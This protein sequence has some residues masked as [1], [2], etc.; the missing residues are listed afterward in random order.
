MI[1]EL[2]SDNP[3]ARRF[4][5]GFGSDESGAG[6]APETALQASSKDTAKESFAGQLGK[7]TSSVKDVKDAK[8]FPSSADDAK[9]VNG[10]RG[11]NKRKPNHAS[12]TR[13]SGPVEAEDATAKGALGG[14]FGGALDGVKPDPTTRTEPDDRL[15]VDSASPARIDEG[16]SQVDPETSRRIEASL[17]ERADAKTQAVG[18]FLARMQAEFGISPEK[19]IEAFARL[20]ERTLMKPPEQAMREFLGN[21]G[22]EPQ[23]TPRAEQLYTQMVDETGEAELGKKM[24]GREGGVNFEVLSPGEH[25]L[26]TLNE[27]LDQMNDVFFQQDMR[28]G[29]DVRDAQTSKASL[30]ADAMNAELARRVQAKGIR[31]QNVG[32]I[33]QNVVGSTEDRRNDSAAGA[34]TT[35]EAGGMS[36]LST[37]SFGG[38]AASAA[39]SGSFD[40]SDSGSDSNFDGFAS[41]MNQERKAQA[42]SA[43]SQTPAGTQFSVTR[44]TPTSSAHGS[45]ET[46]AFSGLVGESSEGAAS[47]KES[48]AETASTSALAASG[49]PNMPREPVSAMGPAGMMIE[50]PKPTRQDEQDNIR[51][52]IRQAQVVLKKGGGEMKLE[53]KPEGMGQVHLKVSVDD[54]QVNVRMLTENDQAKRLLENGLHEL[55]ASLAAEK[56]HVDTMKVDVGSEIKKHMDQSSQQDA[57]REQ[58]RQFAQEFMG[59]FREERE[60]F[61]QGFA[62]N[63]GWRPYNRNP[64]RAP[65]EPEAIAST[66]QGRRASG[67]VAGTRRLNLVA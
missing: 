37:L 65:V 42:S 51:E 31:G 1:S 43:A 6:A 57:S 35:M 26:R 19:I 16:A 50:G 21:L 59:Q 4:T 32:G 49:A 54:G 11:T 61:R 60:A 22:L 66:Q 20:D 24:A 63:S 46:A 9:D 56:L 7:K 2:R 30:S 47:L 15:G 10:A 41:A 58:A 64:K 34:G 12:T 18:R 5:R 38:S 40:L 27:S 52:L 28:Q 23:D 39:G 67:D 13:R 3:F 55:K 29:V 36:V 33:G 45:M 62:E 17:V 14:A 25:R 53:M 48:T 8:D 44:M